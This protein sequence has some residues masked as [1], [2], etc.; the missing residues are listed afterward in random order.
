VGLAVAAVTVTI[1]IIAFGLFGTGDSRAAGTTIPG[2]TDTTVDPDNGTDP[3]NGDGDPGNGTQV[4]LPGDGVTTPPIDPIGDAIPISEL[5]MTADG[6][7]QF[8]FGDDGTQVLGRLR[9][10]F[11]QPTDDTGFIVGTG[12]FGECPGDA[13]RVVQWGPLNIVV[14]GEPADNRFVSYRMDLRYGGATTEIT[15]MTT[16]SGLRVA[17]TVGRLEDIYKANFDIVFRVHQ[18]LGMTFELRASPEG[19]ILLWGPVQSEAPESTVT[20]IFSP[21]P[22]RP[23]GTG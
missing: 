20:G 9:A 11:G 23:G 22:C 21:D 1:S 14:R 6:I 4:T 19:D 8:S 16:L 3:D 12:A 2:T 13:I 18:D 10:T 15:D 17:D 5:T 7:G